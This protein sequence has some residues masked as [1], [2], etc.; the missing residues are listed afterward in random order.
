[1]QPFI[2]LP[3]RL[4]G[5]HPTQAMIDLP[6][7]AAQSHVLEFSEKHPRVGEFQTHLFLDASPQE[8]LVT[9]LPLLA[10]RASLVMSTRTLTGGG[11]HF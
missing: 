10:F 6:K 7:Y 4:S 3:Q 11:E 8:D 9:N 5:P 2:T 1:M